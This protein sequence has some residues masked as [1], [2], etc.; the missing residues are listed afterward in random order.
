MN[1]KMPSEFNKI[2]VVRRKWN[3]C[4]IL[5][6]CPG[7]VTFN[8]EAEKNRRQRPEWKGQMSLFTLRFTCIL[9]TMQTYL[10]KDRS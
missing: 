6:L 3:I 9:N 4:E 1:F 2:G 10:F 8:I 7:G 5:N